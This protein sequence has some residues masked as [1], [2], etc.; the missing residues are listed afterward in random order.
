MELRPAHGKLCP[1]RHG[2]GDLPDPDINGH[3]R[4][5]AGI[6]VDF[7]A[8]RIEIDDAVGAELHLRPSRAEVSGRQQHAPGH[9]SFRRQSEVVLAF[10]DDGIAHRPVESQ[11]RHI[12]IT[13][14]VELRMISAECQNEL[15]AVWTFEPGY[16]C[17]A[18]GQPD[19]LV[20]QPGIVCQ[21][22]LNPEHAFL[23]GETQDQR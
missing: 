4:G 6:D 5:D 3:A 1:E 7:I 23:G 14:A 15:S 11:P 10:D 19:R 12:R 16:E 20:K 8:E 9:E 13:V 21:L 22:R 2:N 18:A 17:E